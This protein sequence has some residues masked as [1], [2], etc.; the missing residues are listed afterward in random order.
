MILL[1]FSWTTWVLM[2][3]ICWW[4]DETCDHGFI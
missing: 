1:Y 3:Q 4:W 2:V